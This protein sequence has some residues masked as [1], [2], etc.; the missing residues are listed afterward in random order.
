VFALH[1]SNI[2]ASGS[3]NVR[4][5]DPLARNP[6]HNASGNIPGPSPE[7]TPGNVPGT[8][9]GKSRAQGVPGSDAEN[10]LHPKRFQPMTGGGGPIAVSTAV[11]SARFRFLRLNML[12]RCKPPL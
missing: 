1:M 4:S 12:R 2:A 6:G 5:H 7:R 8:A 3:R 11:K 9:P 10:A